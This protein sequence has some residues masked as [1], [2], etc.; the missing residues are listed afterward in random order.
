[1]CQEQEIFLYGQFFWLQQDQYRI[2]RLREDNL[3]L[4]MGYVRIQEAP[5]RPKK[6]WGYIAAGNVLWVS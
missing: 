2:G 1:M 5:F 6:C 4:P 3:H